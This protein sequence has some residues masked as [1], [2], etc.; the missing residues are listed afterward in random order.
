MPLPACTSGV[1]SPT[2][3]S[4]LTIANPAGSPVISHG[5]APMT[6]TY[7][8]FTGLSDQDLLDWVYARRPVPPP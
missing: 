1:W 2:K 5:E 3:E 6:A 7:A 4:S 8:A